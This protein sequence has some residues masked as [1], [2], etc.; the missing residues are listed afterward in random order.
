MFTPDT[1]C[2][3]QR[4]SS[5]I[6]PKGN[7]NISGIWKWDD[8]TD[9]TFTLDSGLGSQGLGS[10]TLGTDVLGPASFSPTTSTDP[11]GKGKTGICQLTQA[12]ADQDAELYTLD[13]YV[14]SAG[15]AEDSVT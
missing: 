7:Y 5:T 15:E 1:E 8:Q 2:I 4:I 10:F 14:E 13:F 3:M 9:Q 6:R 12:G 11:E